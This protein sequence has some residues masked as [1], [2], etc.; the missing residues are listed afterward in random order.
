MKCG[1]SR[2]SIVPGDH[3]FTNRR[4]IAR[5]ASSDAGVTGCHQVS[6][7]NASGAW[8]IERGRPD[9][10]VA[11]LDTGIKWDRSGLRAQVHLNQGELPVPNHGLGSPVSDAGSLA[12]GDFSVS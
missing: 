12:S 3:R 9:T 8:K 1:T 6:G 5:Y 2:I 10:V 4:C 11:I 7:F